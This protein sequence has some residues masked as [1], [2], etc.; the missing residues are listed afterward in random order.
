MNRFEPA[1]RHGTLAAAEMWVDT[2]TGV[3]CLWR[4]SANAGGL[5]PPLGEHGAPVV[6][7]AADA[8]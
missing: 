7:K 3:N 2:R 8:F 4:R 1:F 5:T 6:T